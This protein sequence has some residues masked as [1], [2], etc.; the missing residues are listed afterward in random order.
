VTG[1]DEPVLSVRGLE[2]HY[3]IGGGIVQDAVGSVRAVDGLDFEVREGETLG[4]V[5]ESGCGKSTAAA[6][7]L[8]LEEPTGGRILYRGEDVTEYDDEQLKR[9]RRH[10]QM[11][12]Q[13]P[14]STFDPRMSVGDSVAEP[15]L[16][17]GMGER[18]RRRAIVENLLDRVGMDAGDYDRYPHEFSGGQKQRIA[19]ARALV[20]NPDL[21]VADEPVSAL[22]VSV[23]AS[24][25]RLIRDV[26]SEFGLSILLISHDMGVV[27][28]I[29]D[30]VAVMYL[31]EIAEIGPTEVLFE[32]PQHPY[33]RALMSSIPSADPRR[34]GR[35]VELTGSVPSPSN[36]P[37]GCRFHTRCPE[38]IQPEG[39]DLD[40]QQWRAVMD[41]RDA[42]D[43]GTIDTETAREFLAAEA[44]GD[45]DPEAVGRDDLVEHL[46]A[47][48]DLG[49][50]LNDAAAEEALSSAF[51]LVAEA[52]FEAAA[53]RLAETFTTVCETD[54][55]ELG[56]DW[57][58]AADLRRA[59]AAALE[60][61]S[62][63]GVDAAAV[64]REAAADRGVDPASLD[65]EAVA[66]AVRG[67]YD[68]SPSLSDPAAED[69][70]ARAVDAAID[71]RTGTA[72]RI[73]REEFTV[74]GVGIA[75]GGADTHHAAACHLLEERS[76]PVERPATDD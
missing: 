46:R 42:V 76:A 7:L 21:L 23:Q 74:D 20:L 41:F 75:P 67:R 15:L 36:P 5:G 72:E 55:P 54:V 10:A 27:R 59:L 61:D 2:K 60:G 58:G 28:E 31:G 71:D 24:I 11:V 40:Q 64:R 16:I 57:L 63:R 26:Q 14:T 13:D 19:L 9:F 17:H 62:R 35:A 44:D 37:S 32:D 43:R 49:A 18:P 50:P 30:R 66:A 70:V 69:A 73:L 68:V 47:E 12:F 34:R 29:C 39:C 3:P 48:A 1:V 56:A 45:V 52:E 65:R 38:V 53:A 4:L 8:R 22:D 25:L 6:S 33:T 51:E